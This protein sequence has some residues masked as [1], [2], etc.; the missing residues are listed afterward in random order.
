MRPFL[1]VATTQK[2]W[3]TSAGVNA[4]TRISSLEQL[5][6]GLTITGF[7]AGGTVPCPTVG[8]PCNCQL[9]INDPMLETYGSYNIPQNDIC[10]SLDLCLFTYICIYHIY[11]YT[12]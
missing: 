5:Y 6:L 3:F 1:V 11:I 2:S 4:L 10:S 7:G 9:D 12:H 8:V